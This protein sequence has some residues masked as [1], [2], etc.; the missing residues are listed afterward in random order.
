MDCFNSTL[1]FFQQGLDALNSRIQTL[2]TTFLA[3]IRF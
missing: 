1:L 2:E 3:K